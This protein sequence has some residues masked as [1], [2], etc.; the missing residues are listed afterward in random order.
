[1]EV[2]DLI[3]NLR[4]N[5][6]GELCRLV[7]ASS[8]LLTGSGSSKKVRYAN[9]IRD[10]LIHLSGQLGGQPFETLVLGKEE[11]RKFRFAPLQPEQARPLF[12]YNPL[13]SNRIH[14]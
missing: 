1:M 10:W 7:V 9:L 12:E 11:G 6:Q 5:A 8:S 4:C 3:D 2:A 14:P 13:T